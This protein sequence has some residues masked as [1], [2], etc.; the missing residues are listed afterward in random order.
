M[1]LT[2]INMF[3]SRIDEFSKKSQNSDFKKCVKNLLVEKIRMFDV[4]PSQKG[5]FDNT[6]S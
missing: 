1:N 6:R 2:G 5:P 3:K 4:F